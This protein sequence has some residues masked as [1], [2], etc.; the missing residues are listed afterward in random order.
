MSTSGVSKRSLSRSGSSSNESDDDELQETDSKRAKYQNRDGE[1]DNSSAEDEP[2]LMEEEDAEEGNGEEEEEEEDWDEEPHGEEGEYVMPGA[3]RSTTMAHAS[4][5]DQNSNDGDYNDEDDE[6]VDED[7]DYDNGE[8]DASE[9]EQVVNS[10]DEAAADHHCERH[11]SE[12]S[13]ARQSNGRNT[14]MTANCNAKEMYP[15]IPAGTSQAWSLPGSYNTPGSRHVGF[16]HQVI[17]ETSSHSEERNHDADEQTAAHQAAARRVRMMLIGDDNLPAP[18]NAT[19]P[20]DWA[21]GVNASIDVVDNNDPRYYIND[22][23][24]IDPDADEERYRIERAKII[25]QADESHRKQKQ[26][27]ETT[28]A[29]T[30]VR[31]GIQCAE[32]YCVNV[33][34]DRLEHDAKSLDDHR[35][36]PPAWLRTE[37]GRQAFAEAVRTGAGLL[38]LFAYHA[39]GT[40][41]LG[42]EVEAADLND[43]DFEMADAFSEAGDH[44]RSDGKK[45]V[46]PVR[47][48]RYLFR[49]PKDNTRVV[50]M[51][52]TFVEFLRG[53]PQEDTGVVGNNP[54]TAANDRRRREAE[55]RFEKQAAC[56]IK[57]QTPEKHGICPMRRMMGSGTEESYVVV[58]IRVWFVVLDKTYDMNR[59]I[60]WM[61]E[62]NEQGDK[63][64][65]NSKQFNKKA[66][67]EAKAE[68]LALSQARLIK[69][70]YDLNQ[71]IHQHGMGKNVRSELGTKTQ[72]MVMVPFET[73]SADTLRMHPLS[74]YRRFGVVGPIADGEER[75]PISGSH[76]ESL[77]FGMIWPDQTKIE[78][79]PEQTNRDN[80]FVR[81]TQMVNRDANQEIFGDWLFVPIDRIGGLDA[82]LIWMLN[83]SLSLMETELPSHIFNSRSVPLEILSSFCYNRTID[84]ARGFGQDIKMSPCLSE[85]E[86]ILRA[87]K[88]GLAGDATS[89]DMNTTYHDAFHNRTMQTTGASATVICQKT[90]KRRQRIGERPPL[91][92]IKT[93]PPRPQRILKERNGRVYSDIQLF[94]KTQQQ[95][96]VDVERKLNGKITSY[97]RKYHED[98]VDSLKSKDANVRKQTR[99]NI[100]LLA[101]QSDRPGTPEPEEGWHGNMNEQSDLLS[102]IL[103]WKMFLDAKRR[104]FAQRK[105]TLMDSYFSYAIRETEETLSSR[106]N[107]LPVGLVKQYKSSLAHINCLQGSTPV[108]REYEPADRTLSQFGDMMQKMA[109]FCTGYLEC[110]QVRAWLQLYLMHFS[111]IRDMPMKRGVVIMGEPGAGKSTATEMLAAVTV[112]DTVIKVGEATDKCNKQGKTSFDNSVTVRDEKP[113]W[114]NPNSEQVNDRKEMM[115]SGEI[116]YERST[117]AV[118]E[119]GFTQYVKEDIVTPHGELVVLCMNAAHNLGA[120]GCLHIST[121]FQA[122]LER[123]TY[124]S[125]DKVKSWQGEPPYQRN[126]QDS[127]KKPALTNH[128]TR[129]A[130]TKLMIIIRNCVP[131][132]DIDTTLVD[133]LYGTLDAELERMDIQMAGPRDNNVRRDLLGTLTFMHAAHN[134]FMTGALAKQYPDLY[135]EID[136]NGRKVRDAPPFS[137]QHLRHCVPW[138]KSPTMEM[139]VSAYMLE[140][141]HSR[142][143]DPAMDQVMSSLARCA[144]FEPQALY[145]IR[146]NEPTKTEVA[147]LLKT[148]TTISNDVSGDLDGL[149]LTLT[150]DA[151]KRKSQIPADGVTNQLVS[152]FIAPDNIGFCGLGE[153]SIRPANAGRDNGLWNSGIS[154]TE[155]AR[156]VRALEHHFEQR[157]EA[158]ADHA[159]PYITVDDINRLTRMLPNLQMVRMSYST[160]VIEETLQMHSHHSASWSPPDTRMASFSTQ[161]APSGQKGGAGP[162]NAHAQG[163]SSGQAGNPG[164]TGNALSTYTDPRCGPRYSV[165]KTEKGAVFVDYQWI[166]L[167]AGFGK[168]PRDVGYTLHK[169]DY[170]S[171]LG[172]AS[173]MIIDLL[174]IL[175]TRRVRQRLPNDGRDSRRIGTAFRKAATQIMQ[176]N[177]NG[178]DSRLTEL[179]SRD[180]MSLPGIT[181]TND[182]PRLGDR[183]VQCLVGSTDD[184]STVLYDWT[185]QMADLAVMRGGFPAASSQMATGQ[186]S[187]M[188]IIKFNS[189][190]DS[191]S[192]GSSGSA[193]ASANGPNVGIPAVEVNAVALER[194]MHFEAESRCFLSRI[195]GINGYRDPRIAEAVKS[196]GNGEEAPNALKAENLPLIYD[197]ILLTKLIKAISKHVWHREINANGVSDATCPLLKTHFTIPVNQPPRRTEEGQL[198]APLIS[199]NPL[200]LQ[201]DVENVYRT[202]KKIR[203]AIAP[204]EDPSWVRTTRGPDAPKNVFPRDPGST[205]G[206]STEVFVVGDSVKLS[207][208]VAKTQSLHLYGTGNAAKRAGKSKAV[209]GIKEYSRHKTDPWIEHT[210]QCL[211]EC[212][213]TQNMI[214]PKMVTEL[215][216]SNFVMSQV[217][218]RATDGD[219]AMGDE[220]DGE[221]DNESLDGGMSMTVD[222][223]NTW[224]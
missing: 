175:S 118:N 69:N 137:L 143:A 22:H 25:A 33:P 131:G 53:K 132:F 162:S 144:G 49:H 72:A 32:A 42:S 200:D 171:A 156:R 18:V 64:K 27:S 207:R 24:A 114:V 209:T 76:P 73:Q 44:G 221:S 174:V 192:E 135:D 109:A 68:N 97:V 59:G 119:D 199:L 36:D 176:E 163:T 56:D 28:T 130:L 51:V 203:E 77:E 127:S 75:Y 140:T 67:A 155:A 214:M 84:D 62:R 46:H 204:G 3:D 124:I 215:R 151:F 161:P 34:I 169:K 93:N 90:A 172:M 153:S 6:D 129:E 13:S 183:L 92:P 35:K 164:N 87:F 8:E 179:L 65:P 63:A 106:E 128:R 116:T 112:E 142:R 82:K 186:S 166:D 152:K 96:L 78:L 94:L 136:S 125:W 58:G 181:G 141:Y 123:F 50:N 146:R 212:G 52:H 48:R 107:E 103:K 61:M 100:V 47:L 70:T 88:S 198:L 196:S 185:Q 102:D 120:S 194:H 54:P 31:T 157:R 1:C 16:G 217:K 210:M 122:L 205:N 23:W 148:A 15:Q 115:S 41:K 80:Y 14:D 190:P 2:Y 4:G 165:R 55:K 187:M 30:E 108:S 79:W 202:E 40:A 20:E 222:W 7:D 149:G 158:C 208:E 206:L 26:M 216:S 223:T 178:V 81:T 99:E 184:A 168:S 150:D 170:L 167:G 60:Q 37:A 160:S 220:S 57:N 101:S 154:P 66:A 213:C 5:D 9:D 10:D 45:K 145:T 43:E 11:G 133:Q 126:L 19:R 98:M 83:P 86:S 12:A 17:V 195:P 29:Q 177:P 21:E 91:T 89:R 138:I 95:K 188:P 111:S 105:A 191:S 110:M 189:L 74:P 193:T 182:M 159:N 71:A 104:W 219:E 139:A 121:E 39:N 117:E 38:G 201:N 85:M 134:V 113:R 224:A 173:S 147:T 180:E 211:S 197:G 218:D